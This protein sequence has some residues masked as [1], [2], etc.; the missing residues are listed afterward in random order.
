MSKE[1]KVFNIT[2]RLESNGYF[3]IE[4]ESWDEA[5]EK[6]KEMLFDE[7]LDD[8]NY[9]LDFECDDWEMQHGEGSL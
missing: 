8:N 9:T 6:A 3:N 4:A 7:I 5:T 1:K 2:V